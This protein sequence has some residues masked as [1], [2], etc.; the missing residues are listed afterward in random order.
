MPEFHDNPL[1]LLKTAEFHAW[2]NG[3]I[4]LGKMAELLTV[5]KEELRWIVASMGIATVDYPAEELDA[6]WQLLR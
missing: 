2:R 1:S 5:D 4:S 6:E 3:D